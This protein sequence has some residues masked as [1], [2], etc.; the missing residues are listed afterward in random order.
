MTPDQKYMNKNIRKTSENSD[1]EFTPFTSSLVGWLPISLNALDFQNNIIPAFNSFV[2]PPSTNIKIPNPNNNN[3]PN[4]S[5]ENFPSDEE[6]DE[7][8]SY[9]NYDKSNLNNNN[10]N[11]STTPNNT[12][13]NMNKNSREDF[14]PSSCDMVKLLDI[15]Y[16]DFLELERHKEKKKDHCSIEKIYNNIKCNNKEIL[17]VLCSYGIPEPIYKVLIMKIIKLSC[18]YCKKE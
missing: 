16:D 18:N 17:E 14:L 9:N 2:K 3:N 4:N 7:L 13:P 6:S 5:S 10:N 12:S 1:I 15:S 8:F 11:T